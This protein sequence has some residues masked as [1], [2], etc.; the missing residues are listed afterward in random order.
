MTNRGV[1]RAGLASSTQPNESARRPRPVH[2]AFRGLARLPFQLPAGVGVGT[3]ARPAHLL[4]AGGKGKKVYQLRE[5][6]FLG[7]RLARLCQTGPRNPPRLC[8]DCWCRLRSPVEHTS[9]RGPP[10]FGA[11]LFLRTCIS[12]PTQL[13]INKHSFHSPTQ[14]RDT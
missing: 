5:T 13:P 11:L 6:Y 4:C 2:R 12:L 14:Q 7:G 9:Q 8:L 1:D 10:N 3:P